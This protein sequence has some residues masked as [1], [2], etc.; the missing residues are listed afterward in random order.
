MAEVPADP[1]KE[2]LKR[3]PCSVAAGP[4]TQ[5]PLA[6]SWGNPDIHMESPPVSASTV[7]P[8]TLFDVRMPEPGPHADGDVAQRV[9][10]SSCFLEDTAI[11]NSSSV[12]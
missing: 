5:S 12:A 8:E 11:G 10:V 6:G 9:R 7:G 4:T 2:T 1:G 3:R